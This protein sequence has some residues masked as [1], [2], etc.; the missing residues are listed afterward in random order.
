MKWF[1][2]AKTFLLGEYAS[3]AKA[4]A[5]VLT[6]RPHFELSLTSQNELI[7]IH[8]ESPAGLWWQQQGVNQG[9]SWYDPYA[10]KGGVGASSAQFLGS[11]LISCFIHNKN[12]SLEE[13]LQAYYLLSW[14]GKGLKPSGYDLIAQSQGGC[15]YINKKKKL[16]QSYDWPFQNLSFFLIHTGV[17]LTTHHYLQTA[18]LPQQIDYLSSL[19]DNAKQ[20][21]EQNNSQQLIDN[22]NHYHEK[23]LE[24]NLVAEHSLE[25]I[26]QFT[27]YPEV[28][29]VKGCGALGA[30]VILLLTSQINA[31]SLK[32]KLKA[33]NHTILATEQALTLKKNTCLIEV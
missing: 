25:L 16:I 4:S 22:I 32:A 21:F 29:A 10:G 23:L 17:K 12:S 26:K 28:L 1:I 31:S 7:G 13:M 24:L 33:E 19:V 20:A 18:I 14:S 9:L 2:P 8:P 11:Y 5:I 30:D 27:K 6:T 3:I 15:V